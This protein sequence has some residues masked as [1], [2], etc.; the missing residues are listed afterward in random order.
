[1][2]SRGMDRD[3]LA[4]RADRVVKNKNKKQNLLIG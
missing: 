4:N 1:V 3:F 2:E